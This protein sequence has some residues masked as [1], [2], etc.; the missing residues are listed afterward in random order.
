[1]RNHFLWEFRRCCFTVFWLQNLFWEFQSHFNLWSFRIFIL[2]TWNFMIKSLAIVPYIFYFKRF[3]TYKNNINI[4]KYYITNPFVIEINKTL[5]IT[6]RP[7]FNCMPLLLKMCLKICCLSFLCISLFFHWIKY[8]LIYNIVHILKPIYRWH[9][10]IFF[11]MLLCSAV[12]VRVIYAEC[13]PPFSSLHVSL[14]FNYITLM[15]LFQ[16]WYL[17]CFKFLANKKVLLPKFCLRK[18]IWKIH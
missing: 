6:L 17:G 14:L 5:P 4:V 9:H 7:L 8:M 2:V 16:P 10:N 12:F 13:G 15:F 1:M 11:S 3:Q 18:N